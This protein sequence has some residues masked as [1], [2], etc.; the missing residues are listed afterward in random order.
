MPR[1]RA[2]AHPGRRV[3]RQPLAAARVEEPRRARGARAAAQVPARALRALSALPVQAPLRRRHGQRQP[4]PVFALPAA[5]PRRHAPHRIPRSGP[6]RDGIDR[7]LPARWALV[8]L[9]VL[10]ARPARRELRHLQRPLAD[11]AVPAP[12]PAVPLSRLLDPREPEDGLQVEL[13]AD[14]GLHR[15]RLAAPRPPRSA[16]SLYGLARPLLFSLDEETSHQLALRAAGVA[17]LFAPTA[18][19]APVRAMGPEFPNPIGLAAGLDKNAEHI[20]ALGALGFGFLEVGT[21]TPRAQPGNPRPRLFRIP[22]R[23]AI[24]NRLGFNNVGL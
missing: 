2:G 15:R 7:R 10:R 11:R 13:R 1:L 21:V 5:E 17:A 6:A 23:G 24:I 18:P 12:R 16:L 3:Q 8:R 19:H 22:E 4:R 9:Y 14:R 20:E